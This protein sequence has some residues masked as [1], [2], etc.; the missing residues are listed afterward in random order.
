VNARLK[1]NGGTQQDGRLNMV[2]KVLVAIDGSRHSSKTIAFAAE[3]G[4]SLEAEFVVLHV[5][6]WILGPNGPLD[7]GRE[8]ASRLVADAVAELSAKGVRARGMLKGAH[9]G[10][11]AQVIAEMAA[12]EDIDL[13][14]VGSHGK[15][16]LPGI[17]LWAVP[18]RLRKLSEVP[19]V[20]VPLGHRAELETRSEDANGGERSVA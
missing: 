6:E 17:L 2:S 9:S 18:Q 10:H 8:P 13:I 20:I 7:E 5:R 19:I 3:L 15:T 16:N 4:S 1:S 11:T 14:I 12:V